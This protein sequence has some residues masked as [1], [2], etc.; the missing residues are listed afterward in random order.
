MNACAR[1]IT[2]STALDAVSADECSSSCKALCVLSAVASTYKLQLNQPCNGSVSATLSQAAAATD[3]LQCDPACSRARCITGYRQEGSSCGKS[4]TSAPMRSWFYRL[5]C[6]ALRAGEG[7]VRLP[8]EHLP[9]DQRQ[10]RV[11]SR[12]EQMLVPIGVLL[13]WQIVR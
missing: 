4:E 7:S 3:K 10:C 12:R 9:D 5:C 11:Q 8:R 13:R 1:R 6:S 2:I